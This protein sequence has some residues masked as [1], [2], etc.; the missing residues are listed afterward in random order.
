MATRYEIPCT[1]SGVLTIAQP[2]NTNTNTNSIESEMKTAETIHFTHA[3]GQRDHSWGERDWWGSDWVWTAFHLDDGT[4]LHGVEVRPPGRPRFGVGYTQHVPPSGGESGGTSEGDGGEVGIAELTAVL[5]EEVVD[6]DHL[7]RRA[8]VRYSA[9]DA[10]DVILDVRPVGHAPLRLDCPDARGGVAW[11]PR[12]WA[13][14]VAQDGRSGRGWIEWN[15]NERG[16][17]VNGAEE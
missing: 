13:E 17:G 2:H 10:E 9:R 1:V 16:T 12:A 6:P 5:A 8:K 14:V 15:V 11:F 4:H 3:T 7:V